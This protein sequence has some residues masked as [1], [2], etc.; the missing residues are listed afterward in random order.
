MPAATRQ[1]R[2]DARGTHILS[3]AGK[4]L[5]GWVR[6]AS[7]PPAGLRHR[8][9]GAGAACG[10]LC[11]PRGLDGPSPGRDRKAGGP[12]V[13]ARGRRQDVRGG[14]RRGPIRRPHPPPG[15]STEHRALPH[16]FCGRARDRA[17][18]R[19]PA[20]GADRR[21]E[22]PDDSRR[23]RGHRRRGRKREPAAGT[24]PVACAGPARSPASPAP[25]PSPS[26][27][28]PAATPSPA[29]A[30]LRIPSSSP[31]PSRRRRQDHARRWFPAR[32]QVVQRH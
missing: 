25:H 31:V 18:D 17:T 12:A 20:P 6:A 19:P 26:M 7:R 23:P 16:R 24:S 4:G 11:P 3:R 10:I 30:M 29:V 2:K 5:L 8:G 1:V 27:A 14:C 28:R 15:H 32:G 13:G 21:T 22:R 9:R